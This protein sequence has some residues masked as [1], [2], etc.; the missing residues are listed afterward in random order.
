MVPPPLPQAE[1]VAV[2]AGVVTGSTVSFMHTEELQLGLTTD[3]LF[4]KVG[5]CACACASVRVRVCVCARVCTSERSVRVRVCACVN[6]CVCVRVVRCATV[7]P[8]GCAVAVCGLW[9]VVC[10]L[11]P[12]RRALSRRRIV[13]PWSRRRRARST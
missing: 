1:G 5:A 6:V 4:R 2:E 3:E 12:T 10:S 11:W 9:S 7:G 8:D 13:G